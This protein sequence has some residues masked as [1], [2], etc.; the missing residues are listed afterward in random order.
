MSQNRHFPTTAGRINQTAFLSNSH[1]HWQSRSC[2]KILYG[3]S[4]SQIQ[5]W[6]IYTVTLES[7]A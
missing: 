4:H 1:L 2:Y 3:R 5:N 7:T 6:T